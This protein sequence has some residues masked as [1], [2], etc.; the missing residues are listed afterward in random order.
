[1]VHTGP[2]SLCARISVAGSSLALIGFR[3]PTL[4]AKRWL[5]TLLVILSVVLIAAVVVWLAR[6]DSSSSSPAT[7][8]PEA[9]STSELSEFAGEHGS[10]IYWL[11]ARR[12][13]TY[14]LTDFES[15]RVYIRYLTGGAE[16]GDEQAS[17]VTVATYP[18]DNGVAALRKA[19]REQKGAKL[20]KTDDGAV[21]LID[22]TSPDN[23]HLS[24]PG[25]NLQIEVYS[26]VPGEALRLAA[27]GDV[28]P[29]P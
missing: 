22:P 15:G 6:D 20:G 3:T 4:M 27:R 24:Y 8:E 26:P 12:A 13:A 29:V 16:P 21:L 14:E 11:G 19:V 17:F 7:G 5:T 23:A 9:V 2:R 10:P 18:A 28:Q 25:A 1:M